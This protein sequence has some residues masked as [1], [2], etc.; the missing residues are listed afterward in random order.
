MANTI[1]HPTELDDE[2][3]E[4]RKDARKD[5]GRGYLELV[6]EVEKVRLMDLWDPS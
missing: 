4:G 3:G 2:C 1:P 6:G 5:G